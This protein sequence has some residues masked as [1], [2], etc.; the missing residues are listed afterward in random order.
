MSDGGSIDQIV[1]RET[2]DRLSEYCALIKKWNPAI[3]LVAKSTLEDIWKR[4]INDS[5]QFYCSDN[6][7][8]NSWLDLGSGGGLPGIVMAC[9]LQEMSPKTK[10]TLIESDTRKAAFLRTAVRELDLNADVL[11]SRIENAIP[12]NADVISARALARL[13]I[14][15]SLAEP[16]LH[17]SSE[18]IFAKGKSWKSE[19]KEAQ[20]NW[21]FQYEVVKSVTDPNAAILKIGGITRD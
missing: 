19:I 6:A 16:H 4:H 10:V 14:L 15:F 20:K 9:V 12:Q 3:N 2:Y 13:D 18:C 1:S 11:N 21:R 17:K 5:L 8:P 7:N